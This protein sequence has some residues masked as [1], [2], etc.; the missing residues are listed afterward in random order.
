MN[1]FAVN[2][3][4]LS[5][6]P[7]L[8]TLIKL[9]YQYIPPSEAFKFRKEN[10]SSVLLEDILEMQL[11]KLNRIYYRKKV[12]AFSD[13]NISL[14]IEKLRRLCTNSTI[15]T[16]QEIYD[17]IT[18]K[19][20]FIQTI[21]GKT[22]GFDLFYIDWKNWENNVYHCTS[23]YQVV[24]SRSKKTTSPDII[25]FINGIPL[26]II[27]CK[28]PEE[29]I[30]Q[31]ILQQ[32][33]NQGRD[34]LPH[35]FSC[36]QLLIAVNKNQCKYGTVGTPAQH[37]VV[38]K[39]RVDSE[40][41]V[42]AC[43]ARCLTSA[44]KEVLYTENFAYARILFE[45]SEQ[46]SHSNLTV[47]DRALFSLC[48]PERLIDLSYRFIVFD[49]FDKKIARYYQFFA[50]KSALERVKCYSVEGQREGGII[51]QT[52]GSGKLMTM[53]MLARNLVLD[54]DI[55]NMLI[56][57]VTNCDHVEKQLKN[58]FL[59]CDL[60]PQKATTGKLLRE[61]IATK[62]KGIIITS[63]QKFN[64]ALNDKGLIDNSADI[65][66]LVDE[67]QR[68]K[69][70]SFVLRMRQML[71]NACYVGFT[72]TPL[73]TKDKNNFAH[74]GQLIE[75]HYSI[76][77]A[78]ED[79]MLVP[80]LY[81]G[82]DEKEIYQQALNISEHYRTN[83]QGTG[84]KAQLVA[85]SKEAAILY[86]E[87]LKEFNLVTSEVIISPP[88][89]CEGDEKAD[90]EPSINVVSFWKKMMN[91]Y[92]SEE[93]YTRIIIE[94]FKSVETPEILIVVDKFLTG[95]DVPRN[96]VLYLC[97]RLREHMFLQA[98]ARV[99]RVYED[100]KLRESRFKKV[101][102]FVIDYAKILG[103]FDKAMHTYAEAGFSEFN[104]NDLDGVLIN[105]NDK[106]DRLHQHCFELQSDPLK[107]EK[108]I[109]QN[110]QEIF[111]DGPDG[112]D[113]ISY[114]ELT[115]EMLKE[116]G[117]NLKVCEE[118][119]AYLAEATQDSFKQNWKVDFWQDDDAQNRV[120]NE[121]DDH[122]CDKLPSQLG[123]NLSEK[124]KDAFI[125]GIM[126]IAKS[127]KDFES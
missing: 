99:N 97:R 109:I 35:L 57:L 91:L 31:A 50:V 24:R 5:Q 41:E 43:L 82:K 40:N 19:Q 127:K 79:E 8:H 94:R 126:E 30:D 6:I 28:S 72:G 87:Y 38:W 49:G 73:T 55:T 22:R 9:G 15:Q 3:K 62:T 103:N 76:K 1:D 20:S 116:Y 89:I 114:Y 58:T 4:Y 104:P 25:L 90:E 96:T 33:R 86:H 53:V 117:Q 92:E 121:I 51:W 118:V 64:K 115:K 69:Y 54:S 84:F 107:S 119:S 65:L 2:K 125:E 106:I 48:R 75:P 45:N 26:A 39:E 113:E 16:I 59:I 17:L 60:K 63:I 32:L 124:Q 21:E 42:Q 85:S 7:A 108:K 95:F 34:Y 66:I 100:N 14:A 102:G 112:N 47:Q 88:N 105:I 110:D 70:D 93:E 67:S 13:E 111:P 12:Y 101:F 123:V 10:L 61:M 56:I 74:F 98:I 52:Q 36:G 77:Q 71:P 78:I 23:E 46:E 37:W 122:L 68:T 44:E 18:L 80:L 120:K 11:R 81:E 27:E 29:G 83:W